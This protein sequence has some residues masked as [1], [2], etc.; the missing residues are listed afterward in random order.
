M[1]V[2]PANAGQIKL[3]SLGTGELELDSQKG[4]IVPPV[5]K[6]DT[7]TVKNGVAAILAGAF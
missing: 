7:V 3:S 6:G 5:V 2:S 1:V 4:Q